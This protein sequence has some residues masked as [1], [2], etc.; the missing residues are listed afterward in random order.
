[1]NAQVFDGCLKPFKSALKQTLQILISRIPELI[2]TKLKLNSSQCKLI[3][4]QI[5]S[6]KDLSLTPAACLSWTPY[7][8]QELR[9]QFSWA[10][11]TK[12][13]LLP[14]YDAVCLLLC[15]AL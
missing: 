8:E 10:Y 7:I 6:L 9:D 11:R 5:C 4:L 12:H 14:V 1:M 3:P 15:P 2:G 13:V